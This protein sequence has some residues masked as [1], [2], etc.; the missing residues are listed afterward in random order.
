MGSWKYW[1]TINFGNLGSWKYWIRPILGTW[2]PG[3]TGS[4]PFWEPV[5]LEILDQEPFWEPVILEILDQ[6]PFW[7]LVIL[8]ILDHI[9]SY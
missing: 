1:K 8:E 7:E 9:A 6:E 3:N 4:D 5:I 2:D